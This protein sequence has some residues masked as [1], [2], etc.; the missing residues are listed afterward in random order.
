M[1]ILRK[2]G[3]IGLCVLLIAGLVTIFTSDVVAKGWEPIKPIEIVV[4]SA[5]GGGADDMARLIQG[6]VAK[7]KLTAKPITVVNK[8]GGTG[9]EALVHVK[10]A[11]GDII[12]PGRAVVRLG[13]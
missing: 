2:L 7:H 12:A 5:K 9:A 10:N 6:A 11:R 13:D 8:S 1:T 4:I 3:V